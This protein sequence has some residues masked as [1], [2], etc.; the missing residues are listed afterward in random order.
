MRQPSHFHEMFV[1]NVVTFGHEAK[2]LSFNYSLEEQEKK[3]KINQ[4]KSKRQ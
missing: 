1:D 2:T 4:F 3:I